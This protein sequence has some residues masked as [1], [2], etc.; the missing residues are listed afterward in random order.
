MVGFGFRLR[1]DD[2][3]IQRALR[4]TLTMGFSAES[5]VACERVRYGLAAGLRK[6]SVERPSWRGEYKLTTEQWRSRCL[7]SN[8]LSK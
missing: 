8:F 1:G 4:R 2:K 6:E 7:A 5:I 3:G